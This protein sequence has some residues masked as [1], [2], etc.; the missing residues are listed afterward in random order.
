M[1]GSVEIIF[2][3]SIDFRDKEVVKFDYKHDLFFLFFFLVYDL[4]EYFSFRA[5]LSREIKFL[6]IFDIYVSTRVRPKL[7]TLAYIFLSIIVS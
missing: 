7:I 2:L 6:K 1:I 5:E 3:G 4:A